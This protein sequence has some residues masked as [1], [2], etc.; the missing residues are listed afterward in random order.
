MTEELWDEIEL[1]AK[2][3]RLAGVD[4]DVDHYR[5][6][7]A[8]H[9]EGVDAVFHRGYDGRWVLRL[10]MDKYGAFLVPG[11]CE[12]DEEMLTK[13]LN[14]RDDPEHQKQM[15]DKILEA[16]AKWVQSAIE[17][18]KAGYSG[19]PLDLFKMDSLSSLATTAV[20]G[21]LPDRDDL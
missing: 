11:A 18:G 4:V 17:K 14:P 19:H 13:H 12:S 16:H 6:R 5:T 3:L 2:E 10:Y 15:E 20:L 1:R 7:V 9:E 8:F 21:K